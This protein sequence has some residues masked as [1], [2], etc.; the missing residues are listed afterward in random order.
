MRR[1]LFGTID[2]AFMYKICFPF[3]LVTSI[4]RFSQVVFIFGRGGCESIASEAES[5]RNLA[6]Y[7]TVAWRYLSQSRN[8]VQGLRQEL[9]LS[10]HA[11]M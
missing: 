6:K 8:T 4:G 11:G 10:S 1:G 9:S 3:Q 2:L 5:P 7:L